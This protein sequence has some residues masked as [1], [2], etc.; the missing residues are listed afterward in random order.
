VTASSAINHLREVH[1]VEEVEQTK[2]SLRL[3]APPAAY[4]FAPGISQQVFWN[5]LVIT[6]ALDDTDAV[7][8]CAISRDGYISF[9]CYLLG[10]TEDYKK[11]RVKLELDSCAKVLTLKYLLYGLDLSM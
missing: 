9:T 2:F 1:Q 4:Q 5:P 10:N 11:Y 6:S 7:L 8:K 3:I